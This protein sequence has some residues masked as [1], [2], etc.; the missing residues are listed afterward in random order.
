MNSQ[1]SIEPTAQE[2]APLGDWPEPASMVGAVCSGLVWA[3][4]IAFLIWMMFERI[5]TP[6]F[7][8]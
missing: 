4:W 3:A 1:Q 5:N 2:D 8:Q 7:S 6:Q